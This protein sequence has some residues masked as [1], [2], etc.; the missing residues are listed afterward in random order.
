MNTFHPLTVKH[1]DR[2]TPNSVIVTFDIPSNL[3]SE[4]KFIPGQ[5]ITIEKEL[6]G[7][8]LRRAYSICT[9]PTSREVAV[10]IKRMENGS[11]SKYA[12][13]ILQVGDSLLVHPPQGRFVYNHKNTGDT[14]VGFAAGSGITPI[15]S[16][17]KTVIYKTNNQ[18]VLVYGNKSVSEAMFYDELM[19]LVKKFPDRLTIHFVFSQQEEPN[20][21]YGRIESSTVSTIIS[22]K[23]EGTDLEAFYVCGP[24][25]MINTVSETLEKQGIAK[26]KIHFELFSSEPM[27]ET[28]EAVEEGACK[29]TVLVDDEETVFLMDKKQTILTAALANQVDAPYSCQGGICSSCV[30]KVTEGKAVMDKN[31]ILMDDEI[32]D[33]L[34]L[35][36]QAHPITNTIS[37]D[38]DDV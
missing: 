3:K 17:L 5:Y 2:S 38:Y 16:I 20:A 1:I 26:N 14:I 25:A 11:F 8:K 19:D 12:N 24:E 35:T 28:N 31:Q 33:G 9:D 29:V 21:L 6:N 27:L 13:E 18:F 4:F 10:G 34:I 30:A 36:C 22:E 15:M 23:S 32:E 37:I 7:E